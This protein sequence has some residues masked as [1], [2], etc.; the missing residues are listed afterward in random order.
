MGWGAGRVKGKSKQG[1]EAKGGGWL[2]RRYL[3]TCFECGDTV[4]TYC[5]ELGAA[6]RSELKWSSYSQGAGQG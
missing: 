2:F 5:F 6:V 1:E 3:Y 4:A